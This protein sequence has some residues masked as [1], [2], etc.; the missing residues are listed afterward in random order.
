M[1]ID[2]FESELDI[3]AYHEAGHAI[4]AIAC[5]FRLTELSVNP[6]DVGQGFVGYNPGAPLEDEVAQKAALVS[7]S[8]VVADMLL[9]QRSGKP[10][11]N[12]EFLGH[13]NDQE[14]ANRYIHL[15]GRPGRFDDY[16]VLSMKFL[17]DNWEHVDMFAKMLKAFPTMN[18]GALNL[19]VFPRLP[20][21]WQRQLEIIIAHR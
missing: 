3:V 18:P 10:R 7:A 14:N 4:M 8:G 17:R 2:E 9:S 21:D 15:S 6:S 5:G 12:E 11:P 19:D 16:M 20:A 1:T 13:F